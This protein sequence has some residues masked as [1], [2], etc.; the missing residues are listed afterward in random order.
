MQALDKDL[1]SALEK[2][3]KAAR[4]TAE[5]A[6]HAAVDQLGVGHDKPDTFFSDAEKALR[7]RLRTHGK[8]LGDV[9][10]SKSTNPTYGKQ[11]VQHL[12]QEVAYEHWHRMLFAR[13][14]ADNDLLMYDGV[15]VTIEECDELAADEGAKSGWE[16]AGKLAARMLPQV[17]KPGSP[18]FFLD[19]APEHQSELESLL[20]ALPDAAFKASD[21]LGW[22]Y[23]FW[24]ADNKK[25]INESEVRIGSEELPSVTQLFTEP[26]MVAFLLQNSL[27]AWWR[28]V[29]QAS[30]VR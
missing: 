21:S 22:V 15:A 14:L 29:I 28:P 26:Y 27:G 11:Q 7:N 18:V 19:F 30:L 23:Q 16:L 2:T 10:D 12:V 9:R 3:I 6:A 1:R 25:R 13:F 20:K 8:Q 24:Q 5:I 4:E 17:F